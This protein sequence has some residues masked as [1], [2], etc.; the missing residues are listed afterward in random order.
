[1]DRR[2]GALAYRYTMEELGAQ[3][4]ALEIKAGIREKIQHLEEALDWT[5]F[6]RQKLRDLYFSIDAPELSKELINL[7]QALHEKAHQDVADELEKAKRKAQFAIANSEDFSEA[8]LLAAF[9]AGGCSALAAYSQGVEG[10]MVGATFGTFLGLRTIANQ[11]TKHKRAIREAQAELD[12]A[13]ANLNEFEER[14]R[15]P[16]SLN[17]SISG[18]RDKDWDWPKQGLER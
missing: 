5:P 6:S 18:E 11:K 7:R 1:M 4:D 8:Y 14:N 12:I 10:A 17:E 9:I 13:A 3:I 2:M 16:F 15:P